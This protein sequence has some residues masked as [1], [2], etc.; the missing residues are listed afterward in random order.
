MSAPLER[1]ASARARVRARIN[2]DAGASRF[3]RA[4]VARRVACAAKPAPRGKYYAGKGKYIRDDRGLV[5]KTGRD[6]AFTGGFAG[7]ERGLWSYREELAETNAGKALERAKAKRRE[8]REVRLQ[9]DFGGMAGGFP[10]GEIGVKSFNA[11]GE[12]PAAKAPTLGM[13]AAG[14]G[15][16]GGRRRVHVLHHGRAEPGGAGESR[17]DADDEGERDR[18]FGGGAGRGRRWRARWDSSSARWDKS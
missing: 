17:G 8:T 11:T 12:V 10:G 9:K 16:G 14:A 6:D 2:A 13:G 3:A 18:S 4:R 7:G 15:N 5:S 1:G